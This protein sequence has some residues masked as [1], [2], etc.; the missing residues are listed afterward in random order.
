MIGAV[1]DPSS[2]RKL[3]CEAYIFGYPLV[4]TDAVRATGQGPANRFEHVRTLASLAPGCDPCPSPYSV[5]SVAWLDLTGGP[6]VLTLPDLGGRCFSATFL[7]AWADVF[8]SLGSHSGGWRG[9]RGGDYV[10]VGPS[11]RG[12]AV[13]GLSALRAPSNHVLL[14]VR[15]LAQGPGDLAEV[16]ALQD[17]LEITPVGAEAGKIASYWIAKESAL[18]AGRIAETDVDRFF[19]RMNALLFNHP[20]TRGRIDMLHAFGA[21][22]VAPGRRFSLSEFDGEIGAAL[23]RGASD[24]HALIQVETLAAISHDRGWR[25]QSWADCGTVDLLTRAARAMK[26]PDLTCHERAIHAVTHRDAGGRLLESPGYYRLRFDGGPPPLENFWCVATHGHGGDDLGVCHALCALDRPGTLGAAPTEICISSERPASI[27]GRR[28]LP[29]PRG[30]FSVAM[31]F[32]QPLRA[33]RD[34]SWRLPALERLPCEM[35][36]VAAARRGSQLAEMLR[37]QAAFQVDPTSRR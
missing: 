19:N 24:G 17:C 16:H 26:H 29:A 4:L 13:D 23:L 15:M 1:Q 12:E 2:A 28:W 7:D 10:V 37:E 25:V 35:V 9:A 30:A 6:V 14:T 31:S 27:E 32:Y 34:G 21:I 8:A 20:P 36:N 33:M 5:C 18:P 22:G 3:A 11:W